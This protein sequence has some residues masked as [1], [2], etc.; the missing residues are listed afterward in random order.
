MS[1]APE[2]VEAPARDAVLFRS[3]PARTFV[4]PHDDATRLSDSVVPRVKMR[5]SASFTPTK[6]A[7]RNRAS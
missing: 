2:Q 6:R 1:I 5:R 3:S 7:T 4:R